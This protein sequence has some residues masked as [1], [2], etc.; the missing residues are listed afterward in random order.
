MSLFS[1]SKG[2]AP[3]VDDRQPGP[4]K[5]SRPQEA[6]PTPV[7][8][9][10]ATDHTP[11]PAMQ[12]ASMSKSP[13]YAAMEDSAL[14]VLT[15]TAAFTAGGGL[16]GSAVGIMR[17]EANVPPILLAVRGARST[18]LFAGPFYGT[19]IGNGQRIHRSAKAYSF[20]SLPVYSFKR[21]HSKPSVGNIPTSSRKPETVAP[22]QGPRHEPSRRRH[23]RPGHSAHYT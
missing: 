20:A 18:F 4:S 13:L 10:S 6:S 7:P 3:E 9:L 8:A 11:P 12:L 14:T 17:A 16:L 19:S 21:I 22:F 1:S 5:V 23:R 15:R 2:T